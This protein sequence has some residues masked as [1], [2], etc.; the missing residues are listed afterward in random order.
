M[1]SDNPIFDY[2]TEDS[3]FFLEFD[4]EVAT[5]HSRYQIAKAGWNTL[6]PALYFMLNCQRNL[7]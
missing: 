4:R 6:Q 1:K 2:L 3:G 5:F 7:M